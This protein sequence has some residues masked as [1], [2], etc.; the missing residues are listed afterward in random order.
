MKGEYGLYPHHLFI[1]IKMLTVTNRNL[2]IVCGGFPESFDFVKKKLSHKKGHL[3]FLSCQ[4]K[5]IIILRVITNQNK[6]ELKE[7]IKKSPV[8]S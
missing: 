8:L 7:K 1:I 3:S 6:F 5:I 4:N 2:Y